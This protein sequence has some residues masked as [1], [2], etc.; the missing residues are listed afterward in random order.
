MRVAPLCLLLLL[1]MTAIAQARPIEEAQI[2]RVRVTLDSMTD[3]M[4][5]LVRVGTKG[6]LQH[7]ISIY[8]DDLAGNPSALSPSS[9]MSTPMSFVAAREGNSP[10]TTIL[11]AQYSGRRGWA[12]L[13][14]EVILLVDDSL[15]FRLT[16]KDAPARREVGGCTGD[17]CRVEEEISAV[18][19]NEVLAALAKAHSVEI[20]LVGERQSF[21]RR[22]KKEHLALA[23]AFA[24][25]LGLSSEPAPNAPH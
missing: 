3:R 24:T 17:S 25:Y 20:R 12:F 18:L 10:L 21:D 6:I 16:G 14:G 13:T 8:G 19:P 15:R 1:P 7:G 4:T 11:M 2:Q 22:F 23:R 9:S 5:G